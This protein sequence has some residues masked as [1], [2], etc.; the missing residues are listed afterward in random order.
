M[1]FSN[2]G[3]EVNQV[4]VKQET[5]YSQS[6]FYF[7]VSINVPDTVD[8]KSAFGSV[9]ATVL[10]QQDEISHMNVQMQK[11]AEESAKQQRSVVVPFFMT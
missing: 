8:V 11:M 10:S 1:S 4:D 5:S 9:I 7:Q 3:M 6:N 2:N